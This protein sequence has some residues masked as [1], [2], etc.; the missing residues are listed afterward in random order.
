[1]KFKVFK[2]T[3]DKEQTLEFQI[4]VGEVRPGASAADAVLDYI[5]ANVPH[6]FKDTGLSPL[7][8]SEGVHL[9]LWVVLDDADI[10]W[11]LPVKKFVTSPEP[12]KV[13]SG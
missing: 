3:M 6:K 5:V 11:I 7:M 4:E 10:Y 8:D 1:M 2:V 9:T 13:K 12:I